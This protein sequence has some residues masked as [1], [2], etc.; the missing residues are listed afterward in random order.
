MIYIVQKSIRVN[1]AMNKPPYFI[2]SIAMI[3]VMLTV[4][5]SPKELNAQESG[6]QEPKLY[7]PTVDENAPEPEK[8]YKVNYVELYLPIGQV[9]YADPETWT[10][11]K[12]YGLGFRV[13]ELHDVIGT[14][15]DYELGFTNMATSDIDGLKRK[16]NYEKFGIGFTFNQNQSGTTLFFGLGV[17]FINVLHSVEGKA[18]WG[19]PESETESDEVYET[20]IIY[21][22]YTP[23]LP[24][25]LLSGG[26]LP[27]ESGV[28]LHV[29]IGLKIKNRHRLSFYFQPIDEGTLAA[30]NDT[31][32]NTNQSQ[33]NDN[34]YYA[35]I[36][37]RIVESMA[38]FRYS[39][40]FE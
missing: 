32:Y 24:V 33:P 12:Y 19:A 6:A 9:S 2:S 35:D 20:R 29:E 13:V 1:E 5:I 3:A 8:S 37:D 27:Q 17:G 21:Q 18:S 10:N 34:Y 25:L 39:Y 7:L 30:R 40:I 15:F 11:N 28:Y 31:S 4:T 22:N 14:F 16:S 36:P 26:G 38:G 23:L